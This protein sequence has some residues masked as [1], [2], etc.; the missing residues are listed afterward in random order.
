VGVCDYP[1]ERVLCF[2]G[3]GREDERLFFTLLQ[4][5][6]EPQKSVRK[7][8]RS[9]VFGPELTA[10]SLA[11]RAMTG[12]PFCKL[13]GRHAASPSARSPSRYQ[14]RPHV[15]GSGLSGLDPVR[16][17]DYCRGHA[18]T[19]NVNGPPLAC[20]GWEMARPSFLNDPAHWRD[21]AEEARTRADQMSDPQCKSEMLRIAKDYELLAER[22]AERAW[23]RSRKSD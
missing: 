5:M 9:V 4:L 17:C 7:G 16:F 21:R 19:S 15:V 14:R 2:Y 12:G 8:V 6:Q 11:K 23:G 3:G 1:D 10:D 18:V 13:N 20:R 22:A